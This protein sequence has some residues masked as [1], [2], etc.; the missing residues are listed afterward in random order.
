MKLNSITL[1][2][3]AILASSIASAQNAKNGK[4]KNE[5]SAITVAD[6][7]AQSMLLNA[8]SDNGPR[9]INIGLP[10]DLAGTAILEMVFKCP[11]IVN[12]SLLIVCGVKMEVSQKFV[13]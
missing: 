2:M 5:N 11:T 1:T 12:R 7:Q 10:T 8:S 3:F 6:N 9:E 13:Q 4:Q